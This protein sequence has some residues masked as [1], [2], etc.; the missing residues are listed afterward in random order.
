MRAENAHSGAD[1]VPGSGDEAMDCASGV[2]RP[3]GARA[4]RLDLES[5]LRFFAMN[6]LAA[7]KDFP[8]FVLASET[9]GMHDAAST[10]P[11]LDPDIAIL[12]AD[13]DEPARSPSRSSL[14]SSPTSAIKRGDGKGQAHRGYLMASIVLCPTD[15]GEAR[16]QGKGE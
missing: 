10:L 1:P 11:P 4:A 9:A 2:R 13:D 7:F 8:G 3:K 5:E 16:R 6:R 15:R 14:A 12:L